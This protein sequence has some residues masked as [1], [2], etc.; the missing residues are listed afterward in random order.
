[1]FRTFR[2]LAACL[3]A[4][5]SYLAH[6]AEITHLGQPCHAKNILGYCMVADPQSQKDFLVLCNTNEATNIELLFI[7]FEDNTGEVYKA[8]AG[9]GSWA[10]QELPGGKLAV[11]TYYDGKFLLFDLKSRTFTQTVQVPGEEY[12]WRF[13]VGS[14]H[15]L[16]SGTYPHAVL[17]ALNPDTMELE[18]FPNQV[19]PN[20]YLRYVLSLIHI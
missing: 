12:L 5:V 20:M 11:G 18:T 19:P 10:L 15:R 4:F 1:M 2:T 7:D 3:I 17:A 14:D 13:A 8:P 16:Y 6:G 9:Q